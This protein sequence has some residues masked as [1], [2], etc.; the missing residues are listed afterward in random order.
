MTFSAASQPFHEMSA[1]M[2]PLEEDDESVR[3]VFSDYLFHPVYLVLAHHH[4]H[5]VGSLVRIS[6]VSVPVGYSPMQLFH[7][8]IL[9]AQI[10]LLGKNQTRHIYVLSVSP[11][12]SQRKTGC[13]DDGLYRRRD[14]EEY[15][16]Y[17]IKSRVYHE[18]QFAD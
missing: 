11:V 9:Y 8:L 12:Y 13:I 1:H 14:I 18:T 17:E 2:S 7:Y 4:R 5:D 3:I 16:A 10:V 15:G 6:P